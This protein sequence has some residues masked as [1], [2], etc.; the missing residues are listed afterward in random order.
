MTEPRYWKGLAALLVGV[1]VNHL[2]ER[3]LGVR[4]ELFR[5]ILGFDFAWF[6]AMFILPFFV[7]V[8]V[9]LLFGLG[10]KWLCY[11]P[12]LIV[13]V[14]SYL[15]IVYVTGV[16]E[17]TSLLPLGWWGFFVIVVMEA[18]AIGGVMGEIM[19]KGTYG[20]SPRHL[21]YKDKKVP[22]E[23]GPGT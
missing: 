3:L 18:A 17:G 15:Q 22:Q 13:R 23:G 7:G 19:V 1:A 8:I 5:G 4:I 20:R 14:L 9:A 2:G 10:G 16:P 11:F 21:V 6:M 12:P